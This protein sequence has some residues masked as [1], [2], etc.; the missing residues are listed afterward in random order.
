MT[1]MTLASLHLYPVKALA[2]ITREELSVEPWGPAADRRWML[3]SPDGSEVTQREQPRLA[4]VRAVPLSDDACGGGPGGA[5]LRITAPGRE[6]LEVGVP[7]ADRETVP[8]RLFGKKLHVVPADAEAGDWFSAYLGTKVLLV[9]LD[10][11][12]RR[13]LIDPQFAP[14]GQTVSL[15]DGFPLLLTAV[16]SLDALNSL[17]AQG[18]HADEGPV[19]MDRFRPSLVVTGS[20]PWAEDRW[21]RLRVGEA[22]FRV[23]KPCGRC[24]VTTTDQ[25]SGVRGKE[26]LRTLAR[27]RR[28][29][30][31]LV[32]G[33]NLIPERTGRV[34]SGDSVEVLAQGPSSA[35]STPSTA[36]AAAVRP[37]RPRP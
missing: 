34:R 37:K 15:A 22:V 6:P 16:S 24:V 10:A 23:A 3:T 7:P 20:P 32:F 1:S 9:H 26:P 5:A 13:R 4:L 29:G 19:P 14:G 18:D 12:Q 21:R 25:T 31:Q 35:A 33:Q 36:A 2:G 8:V 30:D 11:P 27:H 17:I 28:F